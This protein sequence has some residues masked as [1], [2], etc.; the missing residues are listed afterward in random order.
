MADSI[1]VSTR[2]GLFRIVK[3]GSKWQV[4]DPDFRGVPVSMARAWQ[5][6]PRRLTVVGTT[7]YPG[8]PIFCDTVEEGA[9]YDA[10]NLWRPVAHVAPAGWEQRAAP[11]IEHVAYLAPIEAERERFLNWLAHIEQSP[12]DR[13]HSHY[14]MVSDRQGIGR[15]YV[16]AVLAR[17]WP[18]YTALNFDLVRML[19]SGFSGRLSSKLLAVVDEIAEGGGDR[20]AHAETLKSL[21]TSDHIEINVKYGAQR[22]ERNCIRF[23]VFSNHVAAIP[24]D[25]TDRRWHVIR[26]PSEPRPVDYYRWLYGQ[27]RDPGYIAAVREWLRRRD[28]SGYNPHERPPMNEAKAEMIAASLSGPEQRCVE[29]IEDHPTD[30]IDG[31]RL[32]AELF[33]P[34]VDYGRHAKH[35][36]NILTRRGVVRLGRARPVSGSGNKVT[37][38]ALR[39]A[40]VWKCLSPVDWLAESRRG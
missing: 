28:L 7:F 33:G 30:V 3:K 31:V 14:L 9:E 19:A 39:R 22:V 29:L 38:Y 21:L 34:G 27:L 12:A 11:F 17:V 18:R 35:M 16:G 26:N 25:D 20:W 15:S 1:L 2:K 5:R 23:L 6:H 13:P 10:V 36:N 4:G 24:L 37:L 32:S 40:D 8:Q